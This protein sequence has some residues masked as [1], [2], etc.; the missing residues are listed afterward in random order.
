MMTTETQTGSL[1]DE[2]LIFN[3]ISK[4]TA[5]YHFLVNVC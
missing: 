2:D 5:S 4:L 1:S 3:P